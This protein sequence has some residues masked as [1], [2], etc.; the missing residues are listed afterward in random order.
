MIRVT[1]IGT[2]VVRSVEL[3]GW[4]IEGDGESATGDFND[5]ETQAGKLIFA[6]ALIHSA[7]YAGFTLHEC[8]DDMP[9]AEAER[10]LASVIRKAKG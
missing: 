5:L 3:K 4:R 7:G 10:Q 8:P 9:S 2:C 1:R 6:A